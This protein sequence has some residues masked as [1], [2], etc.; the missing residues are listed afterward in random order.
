MISN[1]KR[2]TIEISPKL[3]HELKLLV[4]KENRTMKSKMVE[5]ICDYV[6]AKGGENRAK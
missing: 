2:L 6:K 5:W 4:T 3:H 1:K